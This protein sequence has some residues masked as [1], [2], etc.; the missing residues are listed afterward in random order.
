[1]LRARLFGGLA[2]A[3][4]QE[5]LPVIPSRVARSLLAH[6][7]IHRDRSH[8][9]DLLAGSFWP[10]RPSSTDRCAHR[11]TSVGGCA[12]RSPSTDRS[13]YARRHHRAPGP[14]AAQASRWVDGRPL[15]HHHAPLDSSGIAKYRVRAERSSGDG[16]WQQLEG[17]PWRGM[18]APEFELEIEPGWTYRWRVRAVD[19]AGNK[20]PHSDWFEFTVTLTLLFVQGFTLSNL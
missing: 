13:P 15:C 20:G 12:H 7:I 18:T 19:G 3:W 16:N 9:R 5:P 6:L 2:S 14:G 4:H 8:T 1:M 10:D 11:P 17:S